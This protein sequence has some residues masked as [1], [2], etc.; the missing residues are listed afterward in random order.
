MA[1]AEI[2]VN[3]TDVLMTLTFPTGLVAFADRDRNNQLSSS[4]IQTYRTE[5]ETVLGQQIRLSDR[6]DRN[7]TLSVQPLDTPSQLITA[8]A[9]PNSHSTLQLRYTWTQPI[10]AL[11]LHY[12]FFLPGVDTAHCLA[13]ILQAGQLRTFIFTPSHPIMVLTPGLLG[14]TTGILAIVGAFVWGAL[15][16]LSPGHGKTVIAAYL[17]GERATPKHALFL[18]L[19]TT[20]THTLGVFALGLITLFATRYILPQ[21]L[22]PWMSLASGVIVIA[23]GL[24][25]FRSRLQHQHIHHAPLYE[26]SLIPNHTYHPT[27]DHHHHDHHD[28]TH[29]HHH[30]YQNNYH[31]DHHDH[32][33]HHH[34]PFS[35]ETSQVTWR[36]L[37]ALGVSGGLLPCPAALVLLLGAIALNQ[38]GLGLLLVLVFSLG[39]AS[40]LTS[41]GL[42]LIYTKHLFERIPI[43]FKLARFFP[44]MSAVCI[45]LI[46]FG[47]STQALM[48]VLGLEIT[49]FLAISLSPG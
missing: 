10:Q 26:H 38:V 28:H 29:H 24:N 22:Y 34:L 9:A 47:I 35:P 36:N 15:H 25:L 27:I 37:L 48:Q 42:A 14:S 17:I 6:G 4:E 46:G 23:I 16:S 3:E 49:Q 8:Q 41:L 21:Q 18:A 33:H 19:T 13:T 40:V 5:L 30:D 11:T 20:V 12:N 39:L 2:L 31:H 43:Q 1:A 32:H 44:A 45:M 7:G